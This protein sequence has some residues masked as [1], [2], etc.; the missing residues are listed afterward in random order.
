MS[1]LFRQGMAHTWSTQHH[2]SGSRLEVRIVWRGSLSPARAVDAGCWLGTLVV[3]TWA[4]PCDEFAFLTAWWWVSKG[5]HPMSERASQVEA[6][7]PFMTYLGMYTGSLLLYSVNQDS[8]KVL[9]R[10]KGRGNRLRL[11]VVTGKFLWEHEDPQ[12]CCQSSTK[13]WSIDSSIS[14]LVCTQTIPI[15]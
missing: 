12:Y 5:K 15:I 13:D 2:P 7:L 3:P 10:L 8:Q 6:V 9:P 4:S 11:S 1:L 14:E